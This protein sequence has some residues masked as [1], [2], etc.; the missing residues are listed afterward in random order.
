MPATEFSEYLRRQRKRLAITQEQLAE[1][2]GVSLS[3]VAKWEGGTRRPL[4]LTRA[5]IE[6]QLAATK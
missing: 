5:A 2:L 3:V 6:I 1:L 4:P